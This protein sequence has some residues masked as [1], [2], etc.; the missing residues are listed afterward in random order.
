MYDNYN[1]S[2]ITYELLLK[3]ISYNDNDNTKFDIFYK[4][5]W[6]ILN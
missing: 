6:Q 3:I 4:N 2:I 5:I 1:D